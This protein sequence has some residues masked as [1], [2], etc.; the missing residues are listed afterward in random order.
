MSRASAV[1]SFRRFRRTV[2]RWT[3]FIVKSRIP[4]VPRAHPSHTPSRSTR[5]AKTGWRLF[6]HAVRRISR[7][8]WGFVSPRPNG[9][10]P[11]LG[12]ARR[13]GPSDAAMGLGTAGAP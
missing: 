13:V 9:R 1:F 5:H 3:P 6:S 4:V 8:W 11:A 7:K 10:S 2:Q 12:G